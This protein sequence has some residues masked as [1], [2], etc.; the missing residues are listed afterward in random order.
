[1]DPES[2]FDADLVYRLMLTAEGKTLTAV[3]A[4]DVQVMGDGSGYDLAYAGKD[5]LIDS[6][7]AYEARLTCTGTL[8]G[9]FERGTLAIGD[10][11]VVLTLTPVCTALADS[12]REA[13]EEQAQENPGSSGTLPVQTTRLAYDTAGCET[14]F[15]GGHV[16]VEDA[17]GNVLR[18]SYAGCGE[19]SVTYNGWPVPPRPA[20]A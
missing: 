18:I 17:A 3:G 7:L 12:E 4:R 13:C 19:R 1:M 16:E 5:I 6:Y 9:A 15:V 14:V 2:G 8:E 11:S 10:G 20:G